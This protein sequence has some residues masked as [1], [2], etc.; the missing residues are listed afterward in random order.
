MEYLVLLNGNMVRQNR[1]VALLLD[2]FSAHRA[3]VQQLGGE[4][5]LSNVTHLETHGVDEP[6]PQVTI[7][8][9][10]RWAV[11][12]GNLDVKGTTIFNAFQKA[13]VKVLEPTHRVAHGIQ[14]SGIIDYDALLQPALEESDTSDEITNIQADISTS[15]SYL[16]E[17]NWQ[18]TNVM[19]IAKFLNPVQKHVDDSLEDIEAHIILTYQE[20]PLIE[21]D[22][23][24]DKAEPLPAP[25][26]T[27]HDATKDY[28]QFALWDE[29]KDAELC[30]PAVSAGSFA[31]RVA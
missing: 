4:R 31:Q 5:G 7:L 20:A 8:Q 3:A 17:H 30:D 27:L 26:V 28:E 21:S 14:C 29:Q 13:P 10:I 19:A 2:N 23:E 16:Q 6:L 24:E 18:T 12:A 11:C 9:A 25:K 1:H 15:Y 22:A